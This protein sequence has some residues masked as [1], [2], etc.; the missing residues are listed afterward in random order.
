[1]LERGGL[2]AKRRPALNGI[3][4]V[5]GGWQGCMVI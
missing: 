1:M 2:D 5:G 4:G 3:V